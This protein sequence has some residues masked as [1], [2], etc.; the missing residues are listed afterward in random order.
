MIDF[1]RADG[2]GHLTLTRP[3]KLNALNEDAWRAQAAAFR[4]G[5]TSGRSP[6]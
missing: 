6:S 1:E 4:P 3:E 2:I 5:L